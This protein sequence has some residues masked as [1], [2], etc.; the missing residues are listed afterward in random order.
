MYT[1]YSS[2]VNT[3]CLSLTLNVCHVLHM[4]KVT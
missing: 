4:V 1:V 3:D 2:S